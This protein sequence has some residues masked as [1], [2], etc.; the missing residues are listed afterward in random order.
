[1][2]TKQKHLHN[3]STSTAITIV[4]GVV[5]LAS[6]WVVGSSNCG[7]SLNLNLVP[8]LNIQVKTEACPASTK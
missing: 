6:L 4:G 2:L 1:M 3:S 8:S 7:G 5:V